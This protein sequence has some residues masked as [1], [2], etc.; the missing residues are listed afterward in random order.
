MYTKVTKDIYNIQHRKIFLSRNEIAKHLDNF[1]GSEYSRT[2]LVN[3]IRANNSW[4]KSI[5]M[6]L[7]NEMKNHEL[8][9]D[10]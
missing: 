1:K 2:E 9:I 3:I 4:S 6:S 8:K 10:P 5:V 7:L